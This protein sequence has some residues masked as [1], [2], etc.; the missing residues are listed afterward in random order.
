VE[1]QKFFP[2]HKHDYYHY[3]TYTSRDDGSQGGS[4]Y[5]HL[6]ERTYSKN[7]Q[8]VQDG[9]DDGRCQH[10]HTGGKG[11]ARGSDDVVSYH[12]NHHK[13]HPHIPDGH[14]IVDVFQD[15]SLG[16]Q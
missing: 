3:H 4:F 2:A 13:K 16:S 15:I 8:R 6:R 9:I 14:V 10:D 1:G 5:A 11:I 7:K 12:G